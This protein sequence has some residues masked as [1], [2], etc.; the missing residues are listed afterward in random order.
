LVAAIFV[1]IKNRCF[2]QIFYNLSWSDIFESQQQQQQQQQQQIGG[3]SSLLL[4]SGQYRPT[5]E[6]TIE[7]L[8]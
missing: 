6:T 2:C 8:K 5:K 4:H 7:T 1:E 3:N